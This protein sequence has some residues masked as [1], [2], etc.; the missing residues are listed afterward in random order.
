MAAPEGR[1]ARAELRCGADDPVD[2]DG[3]PACVPAAVRW[4]PTSWSW[5]AFSGG[6]WRR[7]AV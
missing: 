2:G 7:H 3:P 5:S 4:R 1:S 6:T